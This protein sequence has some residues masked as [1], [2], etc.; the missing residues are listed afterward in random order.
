MAIA[1][2]V[3]VSE[4]ETGLLVLVLVS[5]W[6]MLASRERPVPRAVAVRVSPAD[7]PRRSVWELPLWLAGPAVMLAGLLVIV[8][9]A[10]PSDCHG[11]P[12]CGLDAIGVFAGLVVGGGLII[13]GLFVLLVASIIVGALRSRRVDTVSTPGTD[14][15]PNQ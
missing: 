1:E 14:H 6:A 8:W 15:A 9:P 4:N 11:S 2:A 12:V 10:P 7:R 5:V 3:H 13:V